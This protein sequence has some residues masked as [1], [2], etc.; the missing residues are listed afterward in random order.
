MLNFPVFCHKLVLAKAANQLSWGCNSDGNLD[1]ILISFHCSPWESLEPWF[2]PSLGHNDIRFPQHPLQQGSRAI[3][4]V[5]K[6]CWGGRTHWT[7]SYPSN[8]LGKMPPVR[9]FGQG[10]TFRDLGRVLGGD[11]RQTGAEA[12]TAAPLGEGKGSGLCQPKVW[13]WR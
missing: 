11:V 9:S 13:G 3:A 10:D 6:M 4:W 12:I 5:Q 2:T 7:C 1:I 8:G